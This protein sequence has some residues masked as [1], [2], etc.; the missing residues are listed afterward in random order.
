M[1]ILSMATTPK[2]LFN[3]LSNI[4]FIIDSYKEA[5]LVIINICNRYKRF[6]DLIKINKD[7]LANLSRYP[8]IKLNVTED[9]G[10]ISKLRGGLEYMKKHN[11]DN[12]YL[13]I[14]D[15]DTIYNPLLFRQ[16]INKKRKNNI[17]TGS[18]FNFQGD[19]YNIIK[20]SKCEVVEGYG[21][22]IFN[23]NQINNTDLLKYTDYYKTINFNN[24]DRDRSKAPNPNKNESKTLAFDYINKYLKA[25]FLGDD[26]IISDYFKNKYSLENGR[27]YINPLI[28]GF[29]ADALHKNNDFGSNMGSYKYLNDNKKILDTFYNKIKLNR[30]IRKNFIP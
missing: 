14:I 12:K 11:L 20:G 29:Q 28:Y 21:G 7:L 30:E 1:Y 2:R 18:G 22:I 4:E 26:F 9:S 5:E 8:N 24:D 15:D 25:S 3:L 16:L 13:I 19:K 6:K 23:I 27:N 17:V 10:P